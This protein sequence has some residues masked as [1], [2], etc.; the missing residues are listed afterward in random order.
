MGFFF[1]N[2]AEIVHR[3]LLC[4]HRLSVEL[5][6]DRNRLYLMQRELRTLQAPLPAG[7]SLSLA[8]EIERL[9][10][11]CKQMVQEVEEAGPSYSKLIDYS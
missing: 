6:N 2:Q 1:F 5:E 3:Q 8:D 9:R 4:K 11:N 10:Y 7:G